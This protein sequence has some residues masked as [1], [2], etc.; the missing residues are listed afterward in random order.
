MNRVVPPGPSTSIV[1]LVASQEDIGG[2]ESDA[3]A[4]EEGAIVLRENSSA[5]PLLLRW[6]CNSRFVDE[7][8]R[9]INRPLSRTPW[10]PPNIRD[11]SIACIGDFRYRKISAI[12]LGE[13]LQQVTVARTDCSKA[14]LPGANLCW[15]GTRCA[16]RTRAPA[17][18]IRLVCPLLR[19]QRTIVKLGVDLRSE[20]LGDLA[21]SGLSTS[22]VR[23]DRQGTSDSPSHCP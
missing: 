14:S 13:T 9:P 7:K 23:P 19:N 12:Y 5:Q 20:L 18:N 17:Q 16:G 1:K 4:V 3:F 2:G 6:S 8:R 21:G 11:Q 22:P 10:R 15:D